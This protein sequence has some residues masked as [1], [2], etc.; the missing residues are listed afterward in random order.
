MNRIIGVDQGS[1]SIKVAVVVDGRITETVYRRHHG[2]PL[3]TLI[4]ILHEHNDWLGCSIAFTGSASRPSVKVAGIE[5]VNEVVALAAAIPVF[6]PDIRSVIEMGGQDSKL[7]LFSRIKDKLIFDDFSMN[8]VCA[9]G[10]GSFLDQQAARLG[11]EPEELG[12]LA[13]E[14]TA[15]P[16]IAGRCSVFAKSD[17]IHLQQ[18]GTP[19]CDIVAGLCY[20]VARNFRSSIASGRNFRSPVAFTGGVAAN[21]GMFDAFRSVLEDEGVI[22]TVPDDYRCLTAAGAVIADINGTVTVLDNEFI[23]CLEKVSTNVADKA[24]LP[25]LIDF[26]GVIPSETISEVS[27]ESVYIGIDVGSISTNIA[28]VGADSGNLLASEYLMTA[29]KPL[30]AVKTGLAGI[31]KTLGS[32]RVVLGVG[33][34]GSGRYMTADFVGADIVKNE[35]TAQAR[36]AVEID[37]EV[38]TV[39]EIGGQDSKYISIENGRIVD[40]EMNKVCAAGTG[41]FLEEQSEKLN[42]NIR[43]FGPVALN[44]KVPCS[45]GERCTVFMESD[46]V[47]H[48]ADG[49]SDDN[50]VAGLSYS[51]VRN[52]LNRVVGNR[53]IGKRIFFQG[54]TAFNS[55]V[56]AA[57]N[58]MLDNCRIIVPPNHHVS[59]AIGVALLAGEEVTPG[60]SKFKGFNLSKAKYSQEAFICRMCSNDCE[61]HRVILEDGSELCYG[62]RCERY[63][64]ERKKKS[65][66]TGHDWFDEREKLLLG[67]HRNAPRKAKKRIGIP[68]ALWFW[69]LFPFFETLFRECGFEIEV[70]CKTNSAIMHSGVESVAGESCYP[71]KVAHGHVADLLKRDI[72]WL[73]LP[74]ILKSFPQGDFSESYNCPFVEGSPYMIDAGLGL[75]NVNAPAILTPVLD[76]SLAEQEWIADLTRMLSKMGVSPEMSVGACKSALNRR[77]TFKDSLKEIGKQ[78][79]ES[80]ADD[81]SA[82]VILCRPYNGGDKAANVDIPGKFAAMGATVIP[83]DCLEL[84][85]EKASRLHRNM[86]WYYGQQIIAGALAVK[87]DPRL[88]AVYIT[89]FGCGPDSFIQHEVEKIMGEKPMLT[90]EVDEHAADAG[91]ITR[92]EAFMDSIRGHS[93]IGTAEFNDPLGNRSIPIEDRKVWIPTLGDPAEIAV[94]AVRKYGINAVIFPPTTQSSV[95]LGREVTSGREC[96]PAIITT[97]IMLS[98]LQN[99]DPRKTAFF[100]GSASGPCRFGQYCS[101]QRTILDR[102]GYSDVPIFTA[103]SSDSYTGVSELSSPLFQVDLLRSMVA[104]DILLSALYRLRPYE[105]VVGMTDKVYR[106]ALDSVCLAMEKGKSLMPALKEAAENF[107]NIPVREIRKPLILI[108]GEIYVRTDKYAH[109]NTDRRIEELGGEVLH[110]PL[111]EWFEFVNHTFMERSR[112]NGA[113]SDI[114]KGKLKEK[115]ISMIKRRYQKPFKKLIGDRPHATPGDILD[116]AKPYMEKNIGG[117]AILCI[118]APLALSGENGIDAAVNISPFTCLPGTVVTAISKRIRKEHDLLWLNLA[119]DGQEDT[120]NSIRLEAFMYQV[121]ERVNDSLSP[122]TERKSK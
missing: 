9:A 29:G 69:E 40:F 65:N 43:E 52:Y 22:L 92:C 56:V 97:G 68:R 48:Q 112:E 3:Q 19:V 36:A 64:S 5:A 111:T 7:L 41:S 122:Y 83:V 28:S 57:F 8:S 31:A 24:G 42:M 60:S 103:S 81:K 93:S 46:V 55:G 16:R 62:G 90:I 32:D 99:N 37:P 6:C 2:K 89:N 102:E 74:A 71:V 27:D 121:R 50:I 77:D 114:L 26:K 1:V 15:P 47:A 98:I 76:F 109:S 119:F 53:K 23:E 72:D 107:R 84:P 91:I 86:Y 85:L 21:P 34:T 113:G 96:Y 79:L 78:A 12:K 66:S 67:K 13:L 59:G 82:F 35:I 118:G 95:K 94:A 75:S 105:T 61:I 54:G 80:I 63:E 4:D 117:E 20:A 101:L 88:N 58:S 25:V 30:E 39:F 73:F 116:S 100:I 17:M 49:A 108:F 120:D 33:T 106:K 14:C 11:L 110:T 70:S 87:E 10:T 38:D 45:L 104:G 44:A 115:F 18:I 51:I